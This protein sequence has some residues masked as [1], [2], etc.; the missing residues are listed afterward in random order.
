MTDIFNGITLSIV[1]QPHTLQFLYVAIIHGFS[2]SVATVHYNVY[3]ILCLLTAT[4]IT[5][6]QVRTLCS[7]LFVLLLHAKLKYI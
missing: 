6:L 2:A 3:H 4:Q 5:V 7:T 1:Y